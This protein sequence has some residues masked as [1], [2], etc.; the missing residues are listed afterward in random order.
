MTGYIITKQVLKRWVYYLEGLRS[1][2]SPIWNGL[3]NNAK[4]MTMVNAMLV[5]KKLN[6]IFPSEVFEIIEG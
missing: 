5:E 2:G 4:K 6:E 3:K 1:D